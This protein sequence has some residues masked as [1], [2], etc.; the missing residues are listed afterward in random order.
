MGAS[1]RGLGRSRGLEPRGALHVNDLVLN[2]LVLNNLVLNNLVLAPTTIPD[3]APLA[4][5][6]AA[7]A[8]GYRHVGLRLNRSPGLPFQPVC[9]SSTSTVSISS[10]TRT[11]ERSR[12]RS[13]SA[14]NS[15][16]DIW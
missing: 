1:G 9:A 15:A 13:S 12:P 10:P 6:E 11:S 16:R 3:T 14:R 5:V 7:A 8:A 2:N 4:Y